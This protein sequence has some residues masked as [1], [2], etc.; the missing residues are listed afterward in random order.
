MRT[1]TVQ[2]GED[3]YTI[4]RREAGGY[5]L[6]EVKSL[7]ENKALLAVRKTNVLFPGDCL[8]FPEEP[9]KQA[10]L[11]LS[12]GQV[13]T[14]SVV[15]PM[16]ELRIRMLDS[17][18]SPLSSRPYEIDISGE[19]SKG[20]TDGNGWIKQH[21]PAELSSLVL[22]FA[23]RKFRLEVSALDPIERCSG[24]QARLSNLGYPAGKADG[25][26]GQH[27]AQAVASFQT[28]QGLEVTGICDGD[29][30]RRLVEIHG[31]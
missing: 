24:V 9:K 4:V 12:T 18:K 2:Q 20:V 13:H 23:G 29:T 5:D 14:I 21:V 27:T 25:F 30:R 3:F 17:Q 28:D 31:S 16:R 11:E 15:T 26:Y 6:D 10:F 8:S 22:N 1:Y 7:P 19:V